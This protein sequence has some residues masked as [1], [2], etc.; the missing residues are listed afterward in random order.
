MN[1]FMSKLISQRKE[2]ASP[3]RGQEAMQ[4]GVLL[5]KSITDPS[6]PGSHEPQHPG[7]SKEP[8]TLLNPTFAEDLSANITPVA[9]TMVHQ[10]HP[11][12]V[13]C[14]PNLTPVTKLHPSNLAPQM[15]NPVAPPVPQML[16]PTH[17]SAPQMTYAFTQN[18]C[19][20]LTQNLYPNSY[21]FPTSQSNT[22][23]PY[24]FPNGYT[25]APPDP[26]FPINQIP[27]NLTP[28]YPTHIPQSHQTHNHLITPQLLIHQTSN[29]GGRVI[30]LEVGNGINS[31]LR[32]WSFLTLT[33]AILNCGLEE[34]KISSIIM[35]FKSSRS[36][37][38]CILVC[39]S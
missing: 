6:I 29:P 4:G 18:P 2:L 28:T 21:P 26:T 10:N 25:T 24:M 19:Q 27:P 33:P 5:E 16:N 22:I 30:L 15:A 11:L 12:P 13:S 8:L 35:V 17:S 1:L 20:Y 14:K 9:Y 34:Q 36:Q 37:I 39:G 31:N 3:K 7:R 23:P 38:C 32:K